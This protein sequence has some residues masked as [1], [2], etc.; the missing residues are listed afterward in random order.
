MLMKLAILTLV[1]GFMA[2]I[3]SILY[4]YSK[5][6]LK[7]KQITPNVFKDTSFVNF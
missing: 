5:L 1:H 6:T 3:L 4:P 7:P 2:F